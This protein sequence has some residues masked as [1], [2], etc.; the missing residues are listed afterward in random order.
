MCLHE[1]LQEQRH[2]CCCLADGFREKC[3]L[4]SMQTSPTYHSYCPSLLLLV[5]PKAMPSTEGGHEQETVLKLTPL[6]SFQLQHGSNI[7]NKAL[8]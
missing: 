7:A 5:Q 4:P 8:L 6:K 2:N 1:S 3:H